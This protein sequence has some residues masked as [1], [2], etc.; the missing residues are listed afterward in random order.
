VDLAVTERCCFL[1]EGLEVCSVHDVAGD[2]DGLT[3][4]VVDAA[5]YIVAL[6]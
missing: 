5:G 1:D 6:L 4:V 3:A 2:A